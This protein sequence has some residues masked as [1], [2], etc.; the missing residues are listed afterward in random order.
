MNS[1]GEGVFLCVHSL[2]LLEPSCKQINK[3]GIWYM[4]KK[5]HTLYRVGGG[6]GVN[7]NLIIDVW[8][9]DSEVKHGIDYWLIL[10]QAEMPSQQ[11]DITV[12]WLWYDRWYH[13]EYQVCNITVTSQWCDITNKHITVISPWYHMCDITA[14]YITVISQWY[15]KDLSFSDIT[16]VISLWCHS[17]GYRFSSLWYHPCDNTAISTWCHVLTGWCWFAQISTL[18]HWTLWKENPLFSKLMQH[19]TTPINVCYIFK[20]IP[21]FYSVEHT[22]Q[23]ITG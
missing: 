1:T 9:C 18:E 17:C 5:S 15:H 4:F 13:S 11:Y 22:F 23:I 12:M 8:I 10:F 3:T 21:I 2:I 7:V 19:L 6:G 14:Q 20:H 16:L